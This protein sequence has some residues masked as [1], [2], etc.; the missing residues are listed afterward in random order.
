MEISHHKISMKL[1]TK[2]KLWFENENGYVFGEGAF[3]LLTKIQECGTLKNSAIEL[4]MSYRHAWG[5]IKRIESRIG[6]PLLK[7]RKGGRMPGG[8]EL[9][10]EAKLLMDKYFQAEKSLKEMDLN[11]DFL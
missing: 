10:I 6:R 1:E 11:F 7:T 5:T 8:S 9:T 2:V 3:R 4:G